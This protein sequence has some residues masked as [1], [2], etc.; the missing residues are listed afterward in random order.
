MGRGAD[1]S[2]M[3]RRYIVRAS[4]GAVVIEIVGLREVGRA[5]RR[6]KI[7]LVSVI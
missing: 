4:C 6:L 2:E 7:C 5:K 3:R 1:G